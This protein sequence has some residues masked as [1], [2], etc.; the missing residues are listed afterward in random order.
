LIEPFTLEA[1]GYVSLYNL[2]NVMKRTNEALQY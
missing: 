1:V 2:E